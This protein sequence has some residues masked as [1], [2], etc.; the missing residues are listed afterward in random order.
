MAD[1]WVSAVNGHQNGLTDGVRHGAAHPLT[2]L[3][4]RDLPSWVN[5]L[6][7]LVDQRIDLAVRG[8]DLAAVREWFGSRRC[9][10]S[11]LVDYRL[12]H[13]QDA[14]ELGGSR[15]T[16]GTSFVRHAV[17]VDCVHH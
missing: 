9:L 15:A 3:H 13:D 14:L 12:A 1:G 5:P 17:V 16:T 10:V 8:L 7:Q 6:W 4:H 2:S 11:R